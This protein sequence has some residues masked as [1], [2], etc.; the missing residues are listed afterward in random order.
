MASA[1]NR[2]WERDGFGLVEQQLCVLGVLRRCRF[3]VLHGEEKA[4]GPLELQQQRLTR[5]YSQPQ[6][7]EL[8][9]PPPR[10]GNCRLNG[11]T[12]RERRVME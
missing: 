6:L 8:A 4:V 5:P 1:G 7:S 3:G 11:V 9:L 10:G 2:T 12:V